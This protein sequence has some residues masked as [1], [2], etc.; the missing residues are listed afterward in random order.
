METEPFYTTIGG[1]YR[2]Y[3]ELEAIDWASLLSTY[4]WLNAWT[5]RLTLEERETRFRP[6]FFLF[7]DLLFLVFEALTFLSIPTLPSP[8]FSEVRYLE[9]MEAFEELEERD[10]GLFWVIPLPLGV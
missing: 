9:P 5:E 8:S 3:R 1:S 10:L 2:D 4:R 7:N 6:Y